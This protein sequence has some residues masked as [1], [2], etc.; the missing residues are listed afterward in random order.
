MSQREIVTMC[1]SIKEVNRNLSDRPQLSDYS[2]RYLK[3][4]CSELALMMS[5]AGRTSPNEAIE[6]TDRSGQKR[7][8]GLE[9]VAEM[10]N[11]VKKIVEL[12][13]I[14]HIDQWARIQMEWEEARRKPV[15]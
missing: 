10:L 4:A 11:D 9:E 1:W 6:V 5:E 3:K 12:N 13:L 8:F 2:I 15:G 14:D 7:S